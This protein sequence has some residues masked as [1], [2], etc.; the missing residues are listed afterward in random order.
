MENP[1]DKKSVEEFLRSKLPNDRESLHNAVVLTELVYDTIQKRFQEMD[2]HL[3]LLYPSKIVSELKYRVKLISDSGK[4]ISNDV[5]FP[6]TLIA[7]HKDSDDLLRS[8][9][10]VFDFP[11]TIDDHK[12]STIR[13]YLDDIHIRD[14]KLHKS[15]QIIEGETF[16]CTLF[17]GL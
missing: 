12:L 3:N 13:L 9:E 10:L 2:N 11:K 1:F 16:V 5:G 7:L 4:D 15:F 6:E 14:V 8:D 17:F